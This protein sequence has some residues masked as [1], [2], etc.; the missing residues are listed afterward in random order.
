MSD[1][2]R[3]VL[4]GAGYEAFL[5]AR[6]DDDRRDLECAV[7]GK[8]CE[9]GDI[10]V[11]RRPPPGG[12]RGR[13]PP[14]HPDHRRVRVLDGVELQQGAPARGGLRARTARPAWWCVGSPSTT[15]CASTSDG[16]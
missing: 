16:S 9:Q 6:I 5:P 12:R 10:V 11:C 1:N 7:V 3:P 15:W 8:H 2:P 4:Y 13:R 14:R